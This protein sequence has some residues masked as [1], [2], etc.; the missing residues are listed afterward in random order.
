MQKLD[1]SVLGPIDRQSFTPLY[2]QIADEIESHLQA[3]PV[4]TMLPSETEIVAH[5]NVSRGVAVQALKELLHRNVIVRMQGSGTFKASVMPARFTRSLNEV[6]LPSFSEDLKRTGHKTSERVY[7]CELVAGTKAVR[8]ALK[9]SE[10]G[11]A[12][13]LARTILADQEP[14]VYLI[15]YLSAEI[16]S[17]IDTTKVA[18]QSLYGYLEASY[19]AGYRPAWAE[20]EY[21]AIVAPPWLRQFLEVDE[22]S[23]LLTST[24][25]AYLADG[26]P[27]EYVQSYMRG[28]L[29]HVKVT[30]LPALEPTNIGKLELEMRR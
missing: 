22:N 6:K 4:G 7:E 26:R 14:V 8:Q 24:R 16:Y 25:I 1:P 27:S 18:R 23:P 10:G 9:L 13:K 29:Y 20:E 2:R 12:W 19:G 3:L 30:V 21:S 15:S 5:Y 28:E 11:Q 17:E